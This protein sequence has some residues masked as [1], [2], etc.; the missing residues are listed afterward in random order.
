MTVGAK[1][2]PIP[3]PGRTVRV[4]LAAD[5]L[6]APCALEMAPIGSVFVRLPCWKEVTLT[7]TLQ[8]AFA[9][10][11]APESEKLPPLDGAL[12]EPLAQVVVPAGTDARIIPAGRV[13]ERETPERAVAVRF[14]RDTVSV[15]VPPPGIETGEKLLLSD[16][17]RAAFVSVAEAAVTFRI[18]S[19]SVSA[20]AGIVSIELAAVLE[21]TSTTT[22]HVPGVAP[23]A[24]G[25]VA[26]DRA[27][28]P[29]PVT[30][31]TEPPGHVVEAFGGEAIVTSCAP[32]GRLSVRVAFV[33]G[34]KRLFVMVIVSVERPPLAIVAGEKAFAIAAPAVTVRFAL[35]GAELVTPCVVV[36]EFAGIVFV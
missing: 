34:E 5:G 27:T 13:S 7:E 14:V 21:V 4:A 1:L 12:T 17:V 31:A 19:L 33:S 15:D 23:T 22:T 20:F 26:P 9:A 10:I 29:P 2:F 35:I 28:D 3:A 25:M 32:T 18:P 8:V 16:T 30:A 6:V 24:A 11:E 36:R